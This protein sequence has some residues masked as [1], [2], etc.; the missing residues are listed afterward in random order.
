MKITEKQAE[1]I[2]LM[3]KKQGFMN[4]AETELFYEICDKFN[5]DYE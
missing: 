1:T 2:Y 5:F 4:E 3:L